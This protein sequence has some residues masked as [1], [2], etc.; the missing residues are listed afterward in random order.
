M[1]D[2]LQTSEFYESIGVSIGFLS[3][4]FLCKPRHTFADRLIG[5]SIGS[6]FGGFIGNALFHTWKTY[7]RFVV[8]NGVIIAGSLLSPWLQKRLKNDELKN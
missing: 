3:T 6:F 2:L 5:I 7:P 4:L 1:S 8:Y